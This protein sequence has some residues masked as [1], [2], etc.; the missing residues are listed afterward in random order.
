MFYPFIN[1]DMFIN[2]DN[3]LNTAKSYFVD[4]HVKK[5]KDTLRHCCCKE[6]LEPSL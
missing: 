3:L 2:P 5:K 6:K 1:L 4:V